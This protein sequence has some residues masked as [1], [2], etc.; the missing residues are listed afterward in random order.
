MINGMPIQFLNGFDDQPKF[1]NG[2]GAAI[3]DVITGRDLEGIGLG[4]TADDDRKMYDYLVKTRNIIATNPQ[5]VATVQ[6]PADMIKM[7]DYAIQYWYT[8]QR[9]KALDILAEQEEKLI[10]AGAI[11]AGYDLSGLAGEGLDGFWKSIKTGFKKA[12]NAVKTAAKATGQAV[13][14]AAK[15]VITRLNPVAIAARTGFLVA[16][17]IN[18]NHIASKVAPGYLTPAEAQ[19]EGISP[20]D[21]QKAVEA[22]DKITKMYTG[23]LFGKENVLKKAILSGKRKKWRKGVSLDENQIS[24]SVN[25]NAGEANDLTADEA[26]EITTQQV[27]GVGSAAAASS[28]AAA[29]P[30]IVKATNWVKDLF[31]KGETVAENA[32][33]NVKE[34]ASVAQNVSR[35]VQATSQAFKQSQAQSQPQAQQD[36]NTSPQTQN[37]MD[38][39]NPGLMDKLKKPATWLILAGIG[40]AGY[41]AYKAFKGSSSPKRQA[42]GGDSAPALNGLEGARRGKA[43]RA[44]ALPA[45]KAKTAKR[46]KSTKVKTVKL[47]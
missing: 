31:R 41:F 10:K 30:W 42:A 8:P 6:N 2:L 39:P 5:M 18:L 19:A 14:K 45:P 17:K 23:K 1:I 21:H 13:K 4:S 35:T 12:G 38:N 36:Q 47:H 43:R 3:E 16:M 46:R 33:A 27:S 44:A 20:A 24:Q 25:A 11:L 7:F 37:A 26:A 28:V 34:A 32:A 29:A 40:V 15:F 22:L 9:D